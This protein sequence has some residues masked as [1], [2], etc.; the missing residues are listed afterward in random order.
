LLETVGHPIRGCIALIQ[1]ALGELRLCAGA[2]RLD[3]ALV[4]PPSGGH[5]CRIRR[6]EWLETRDDL[7][8]TDRALLRR[9]VERQIDVPDELQIDQRATLGNWPWTQLK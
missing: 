7:F 8:D 3:Q 1:G 5:E 4:R 2:R 6:S 9:P